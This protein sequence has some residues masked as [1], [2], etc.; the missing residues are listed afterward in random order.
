[1]KIALC[2]PCRSG[3]VRHEHMS[4]IIEILRMAGKRGHKIHHYVAPGCSI[5][6]RVRNRL[7]S[8]AL[9]EGCEWVV[10]V[11]DDIGCEAADF[12]KLI[13][14]GFDVVA[15][16]PAK[17]H[18]RWDEKGAAVAKFGKQI[19]EIR[20]CAGRVWQVQRLA[21]AFMAIRADVFEKLEPVT[22]AFV[23]EGDPRTHET[24]TWFWF[25]LITDDGET[26]DEG[27]DYNFCRKWASIGGKCYLDPDIRLRHY[28]GNV[29]HDFCPADMEITEIA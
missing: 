8:A 17:R 24:R 3:Y 4:S 27:E 7:V 5:L 15:A 6:P 28:D 1:M 22:T 21:T 29:C 20:T 23:S 16:A 10:F 11:D 26:R 14:H 2:T 13:E 9:G 18:T 12:F 25:D 19:D